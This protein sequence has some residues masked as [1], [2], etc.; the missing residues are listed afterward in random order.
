MRASD[1]HTA[2]WRKSSH[3]GSQA[4]S[5]IEVASIWHKSSRSSSITQECVEVASAEQGVAVRDSKDPDGP[6]LII[7]L[8]AWSNVLTA[9]KDR[10]PSL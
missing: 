7:A 2:R 1:V 5:C 4:G 9:L 10:H 3:S 6:V 8:R